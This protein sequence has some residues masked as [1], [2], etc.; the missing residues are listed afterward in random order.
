M[1]FSFFS[2]LALASILASEDSVVG[3]ELLG[4]EEYSALLQVST[5]ADADEAKWL[6]QASRDEI[7]QLMAEI[8]AVNESEL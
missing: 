8:S 3:I 1:R 5:E 2:S 4:D 6:A 7:E